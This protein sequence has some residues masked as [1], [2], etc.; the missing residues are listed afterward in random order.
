M[1][2]TG[3]NLSL[4]QKRFVE[5]YLVTG[6][7]TEAARRAGYNATEDA[8]RVIGCENLT[9]LSIKR[10]IQ[11]RLSDA[12]VTA[13]EV[14]GT[15]ASQMRGDITDLFNESGGFSIQEIRDKGLGHLIKKVKLKREWEDAGEDEAKIPVDIIEIEF[16]NSQA[17]A[18]QLC[19][20]LGIER[21][22]APNDSDAKKEL[23]RV[24]LEKR[25]LS[26]TREEA[27]EELVA[28]GVDREDLE[29]S[30]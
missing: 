16:H 2:R 12:H 1:P 11:A 7:A 3:R 27:I 24:M 13:N 14:I 29:V 22:P 8:L 19:K 18:Q 5:A 4:K 26:C 21:E 6:N 10:R 30:A 25:M 23:A 28:L 9:K 20:V 15:L 17:A